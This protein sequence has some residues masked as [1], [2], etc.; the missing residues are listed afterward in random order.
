MSYTIN[1]FNGINLTQVVDGSIDQ[2]ATDLVLVGKNS[3][4]YGQYINDNFVWLLENFA[5]SSQ[6]NHPITGQLWFDTTQNRLKVY[7]G[8]VFKV[9]GGSIVSGSVP[10][11]IAT[12]DIWINST[13]EQLY[14]NDGKQTLLA[15][16]IYTAAQGQ[17]GFVVSDIIDTNN[18]SHTVALVYVAQTLMGIFS[19]DSFT[20]ASPIAGFAGSITVGFNA[21]TA[22]GFKFNTPVSSTYSLIAP[23]GTLKT[24]SSFVSTTSSSNM[25]GTLTIQNAIPL[26]LG[27][28]ASTEIDVTATLFNISSKASNQNFQITTLIGSTPYPAIYVNS[29]TSRV[30]I[31]TNTPTSTLDVAGDLTVEGNLNVLGTT[32]TINTV[33]V[34]ISD[35]VII[36]GTVTTPTDT[37]ANGGGIQLAGSTPKTFTWAS[38][39]SSWT[40]S[41]NINIVSGKT[42]KINGFDVVTANS[43]GSVI[44]S[45]PG[46][47]T[48]GSLTSLTAGSL[49]ITTNALSVT[50]ANTNLSL[51]ANG[52]GTVDVASKKITSLAT[53][54]LGTDAANKNYVD[55]STQLAPQAIALTTTGYSNL[56]IASN[57]IS[58][59]FPISEHQNN[60]IVRA[61]CTDIGNTFVV[62]AGSF[63]TNSVYMIVSVGNTSF[64]GLGAASNTVGTIFVASGAGSGSGTAA[65]VIRTFQLQ[66]GVWT[67]VSY[68]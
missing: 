40:S 63:V 35:K 12:G 42:L 44:T 11:S 28:N 32:T 2:T 66:S 58:K 61:F 21:G 30:G 51:V 4:S 7:D 19:K 54:T 49:S 36:L 9:S 37:T 3:S 57:F 52:T 41:E 17:T 62:T 16:P 38:S 53:P 29:T 13:T 31:F 26:I 6:P 8:S 20:P 59:L 22:S 46:L 67:Y 10:S 27:S 64:T 50:T 60:M 34:N 15:G 39:G 65:P 23:D 45:A 43:L 47:S 14:F 48:I 5:N 55:A 25:T 33:N 24:T 18:F 56:Q 68:S 1:H